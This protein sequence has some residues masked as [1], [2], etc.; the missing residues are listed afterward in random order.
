MCQHVPMLE[1]IV[2]F[3]MLCGACL[4]VPGNGFLYKR[5]RGLAGFLIHVGTGRLEPE[6]VYD[7]LEH[8]KRTAKVQ[9]A[10]PHGL[11]LRKV[12]Y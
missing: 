4:A 8:G 1:R 6:A 10:Q 3:W 11:F 9:T 12:F 5:V 7:I 2:V